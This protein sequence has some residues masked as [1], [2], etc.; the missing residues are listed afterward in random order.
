[1]TVSNPSADR[2][3]KRLGYAAAGI[4]LYLLVDRSA[5]QTILFSEP[6]RGRYR[7]VTSHEI[8]DPVALPA[9]FSFTLEDLV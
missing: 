3:S 7:T 8:T 4:P 9:P 5:K 6:T 1:M 2:D